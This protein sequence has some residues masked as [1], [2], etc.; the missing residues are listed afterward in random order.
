MSHLATQMG[1]PVG[2]WRSVG[3]SHNAFFSE[4]FVDELAHATQTDP[5]AFRRQHLSEKHAQRHLA[6]L[7][8]VAEKAKWGSKLPAGQA[9][10]IALHESFNSIVAQ[11]VEV[12]LV[13]GVPKVH[14]VV[15]AVDCGQVV[16]PGI[17]AQ[18]VEGSV[19]YAL[20]AA[21]WGRI[22]IRAGM[23]QQ[24]NYP[25][26]RMLQL[27]ETPMIETHLMPSSRAPS[28]IGEP[29]VPPLAPALANA[30]FALTGQ[31]L[32]SLPLVKA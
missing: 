9:R 25:Q 2:F 1:V 31:R 6:V 26:Y 3:H 22:D 10:G 23:V 11:V 15:C 5:L 24:T 32:R 7:N 30:L 17:V 16:N 29:A 13:N 14:K 8:L 18:Q 19:V 21:L 28:G 20:S 4:S 27:S 12:S